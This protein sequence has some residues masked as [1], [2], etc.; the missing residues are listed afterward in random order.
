MLLSISY[1]NFRLSNA[2]KIFRIEPVDS[3]INESQ[4]PISLGILRQCRY[5]VENKNENGKSDIVGIPTVKA[6][7]YPPAWQRY[8]RLRKKAEA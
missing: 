8:V 1:R 4:K 7:K 3:E 5:N 2:Y 6:R